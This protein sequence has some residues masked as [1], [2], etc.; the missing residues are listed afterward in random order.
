MGC[1]DTLT[2]NVSSSPQSGYT[3]ENWLRG[4]CVDRLEGFLKQWLFSLLVSSILKSQLSELSAVTFYSQ[5][6]RH[7]SPASPLPATNCGRLKKSQLIPGFMETIRTLAAKSP[8]LTRCPVAQCD[9]KNFPDHKKRI[10][11]NAWCPQ[12]LLAVC[13]LPWSW[14]Q[15]RG[16]VRSW[17]RPDN[18]AALSSL[19]A[20]CR[21]CVSW[22]LEVACGLNPTKRSDS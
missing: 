6:D 3:L 11:D 8:H 13:S 19:K 12:R 22:S 18:K 9:S 1:R 15:C 20:A 2:P 7:Q 17:Q 10:W 16:Q 21:V 5:V 4:T 14:G